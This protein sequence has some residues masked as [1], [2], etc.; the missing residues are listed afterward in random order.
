MVT[1]TNP[2]VASNLSEAGKLQQSEGVPS[3]ISDQ[4]VPTLD[5]NPVP[6]KVV[7]VVKVNSTT[8]TS[9]TIYTT[10]TD[11]D[12]YLTGLE[13]SIS[14]LATNTATN[15]YIQIEVNGLVTK[16]CWIAQ[17]ASTARDAEV[18]RDFT[19]PIKVDRG[20]AIQIIN[21]AG[22]NILSLGVVTGFTR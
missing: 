14:K 10:P 5:V 19:Y 1:N 3:Q 13:L 18:Q 4:Y 16:L 7:D 11:E 2:K 6:T 22:T 17:T 12:F 15:S 20:S 21:S 8:G 9:T